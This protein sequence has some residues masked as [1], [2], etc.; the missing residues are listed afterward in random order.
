MIIVGFMQFISSF[1]VYH[2]VRGRA[3]FILSCTIEL[4]AHEESLR[5]RTRYIYNQSIKSISKLR[6]IAHSLHQILSVALSNRR[7][8]SCENRFCRGKEGRTVSE[9]VELSLYRL[10]QMTIL[11]H[12]ILR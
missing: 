3:R 5:S 6:S 4:A 11:Y 8:I 9:T 12:R 1:A 10:R 2:L 7:L